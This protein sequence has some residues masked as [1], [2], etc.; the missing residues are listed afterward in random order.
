M[1]VEHSGNNIIFIGNT[2]GVSGNYRYYLLLNNFS[3]SC[4]QFEFSSIYLFINIATDPY[5][6]HLAWL[7]AVHERNARWT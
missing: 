5:T 6:I 1:T 7:Q 4:I 2:V 3:N